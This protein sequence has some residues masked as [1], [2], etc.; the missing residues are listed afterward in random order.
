MTASNLPAPSSPMSG[1]RVARAYLAEWRQE[2]LR[3]LRTPAFALPFLAL[4]APIYLFFGVVIA[5]GAVAARPALASYLFSGWLVFAATMPGLFGVGCGLALERQGGLLRLK[6]ALP[7]PAG[8]VI[9]AKMGTAAVLAA[10]A[11]ALVVAAAA[12]AGT[13]PLPGPRIAAMCLAL[14]AGTVPM[15]ALGLFIGAHASGSAAPAITNLVFLPMLWLSGLFIPLPAFLEPWV[16]VW[17]AFHLNQLALAAAGVHEFRFIPPGIAAAAL[18]G[19]T[20]VFGGLAVRRLAER[21]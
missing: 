20:V 16:V 10:L 3:V 11:M 19:V 7:A 5:G 21:G 13:L 6:R 17:P 4:P 2:T 14:L 12:V 8:A 15:S 18:A 9:L 1:A